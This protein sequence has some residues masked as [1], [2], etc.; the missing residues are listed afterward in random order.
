MK[1]SQL[2]KGHVVSLNGAPFRV[3]DIDVSTPTARGGNTLY[4]V[5]FTGVTTG[6]NLDQSF[7][8]N[9]ALEELTLDRRPI[10]YLYNDPDGYHFMDAENFEQYS[11]GID[12]VED[13]KDWLIENMEGLS[14]LLLE[15]RIVAIELP[16]A[17][18]LDIVETAPMIKGAT[19]TSRN[20][21]ATLSNGRVVLVPEY[22][23]SGDRVRVNTETGKFMSRV[24]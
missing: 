14:A 7:K 6:Q 8:S 10:T 23:A 4:R 5:K 22:L 11:L 12:Q 9:D 2:R 15:G 16:A 1:A 20:K 18:D 17:V 13:Q 24:K 19:A 3:R 21:P